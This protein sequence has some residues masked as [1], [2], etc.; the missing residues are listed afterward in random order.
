MQFS[1]FLKLY[2][3]SFEYELPEATIVEFAGEDIKEYRKAKEEYF[4]NMHKVDCSFYD[5][6]YDEEQYREFQEANF[7]ERFK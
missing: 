1:R 3:D 6:D 4:K 5:Y 7:Y 2:N